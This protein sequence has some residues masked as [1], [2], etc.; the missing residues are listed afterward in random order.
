MRKIYFN[1]IIIYD[2]LKE[3]AFKADF[4][5]GINIITSGE[6]HVGKSCLV[7]S[8]YYALGADI[9]FASSWDL[10][11]KTVYLKFTVGEEECQIIRH[12]KSFLLI[13][14]KGKTHFCTRIASELTH[15]L[16][17][18]FGFSVHLRSKRSKRYEEA[19]PAFTYLPYYISYL[20]I[21]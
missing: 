2:A 6:N 16:A 19:P 10:K 13:D 14:G 18:V 15:H 8:L 7:K 5:L 21:D 17:S 20:I 11:N 9:N 3:R 12:Q 1:T 4:N